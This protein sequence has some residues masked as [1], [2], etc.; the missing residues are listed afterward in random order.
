MYANIEQRRRFETTQSFHAYLSNYH[1]F[2]YNLI[3]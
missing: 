3:A 2:I 1:L